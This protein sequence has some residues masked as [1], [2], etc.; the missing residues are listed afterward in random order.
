[1]TM[2]ELKRRQQA[3]RQASTVLRTPASTESFFPPNVMSKML[4]QWKHFMINSVHGDYNHSYTPT[5]HKGQHINSFKNLY[6]QLYKHQA[7]LIGEKNTCKMNP[8]FTIT[9]NIETQYACAQQ[10][11][12]SDSICSMMSAQYITLYYIRHIN[13]WDSVSLNYLYLYTSTC[14][15]KINLFYFNFKLMVSQDFII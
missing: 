1:M 8:L 12:V 7:I 13:I 15:F 11:H 2:D 10:L 14:N 5:C 6:I 9:Y 3:G 4:Q